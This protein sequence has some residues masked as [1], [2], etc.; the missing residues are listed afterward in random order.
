MEEPSACEFVFQDE[1]RGAMTEKVIARE[2]PDHE[3]IAPVPLRLVNQQ[4]GFC[5]AAVSEMVATRGTLNQSD[6]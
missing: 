5:T 4:G 2:R 3:E 6:P 1:E